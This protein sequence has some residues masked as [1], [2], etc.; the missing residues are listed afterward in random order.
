[1]TRPRLAQ[2]AWNVPL[3]LAIRHARTL[4]KP[5]GVHRMP[6]RV[7]RRCM[8]CV[9]APAPAPEPPARP[10]CHGSWSR[11]RVRV[12]STEPISWAH[13][14][15]TVFFQGRIRV[16][17]LRTSPPRSMRRAPMFCSTQ[18]L[19]P[20]GLLGDRRVAKAERCALR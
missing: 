18:A 17:A 12:R 8:T 10:A 3:S 1:M 13:T 20:V 6:A 19:A 11:R 14:S 15:R 2:K 16:R 7:N 4:R 5:G 9:H